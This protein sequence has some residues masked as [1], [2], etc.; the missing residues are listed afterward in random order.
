MALLHLSGYLTQP[1]LLLLLL[2]TLPMAIYT[3][4]LPTLVA[5]LGTLTMLPSLLYLLGQAELHRDWPRRILVYPVLLFLGV[6]ITWNSTL[7]ILDGLRPLGRD[8][9]THT[10]VQT[11]RTIRQTG[12]QPTTA[13]MPT[14]RSLER[15]CSDYTQWSPSY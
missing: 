6:G 1:L 10:E 11:S 9:P 3:P 4:H 8:I 14:A 5:A 15:S 12:K 7:A 2:L 13:Q